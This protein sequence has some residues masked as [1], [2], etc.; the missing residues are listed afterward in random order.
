M[1]R[2]AQILVPSTSSLLQMQPHS[3]YISLRSTACSQRQ[4]NPHQEAM[5][6]GQ[7]SWGRN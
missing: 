6:S 2:C 3:V 4:E 5:P 1:C 7:L